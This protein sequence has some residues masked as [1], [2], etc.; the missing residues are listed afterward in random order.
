MSPLRGWFLDMDRRFRQIELP[1]SARNQA[2]RLRLSGR[3]FV[4]FAAVPPFGRRMRR[5]SRECKGSSTEWQSHSARLAAQPQVVPARNLLGIA[6]LI[7]ALI[8]GSLYH[9]GE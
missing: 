7:A 2:E 4:D 1:G 3:R 6:W 9:R 5:H 8:E